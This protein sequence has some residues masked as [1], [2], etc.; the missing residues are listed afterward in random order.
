MEKIKEKLKTIHY[1]HY[2]GIV[3]T[4][5][6]ILCSIFLFPNAF[7]R[8]VESIK[9]LWNSICYYFKEMFDLDINAIPT[10]NESSSVG[11]TPFF[12]LPATWE[13]FQIKWGEFWQLFINGDNIQE[14]LSHLTTLL[15]NFSKIFL[16]I[17][18]PMFIILYFLFQRYLSSE[19][20]DYNKDSK[21]LTFFKWLATKTYIPAK[22]W[23]KQFLSFIGD[24]KYKKIWFWIWAFN[25][26]FITII[27]E[28][29]AFYLYFCV[30]FEFTSIYKQVYK[31]VRDLSV[32]IAFIPPV[33]WLVLAYLFL[34]YIRKKIGST[35]GDNKYIINELGVGYRIGED[36]QE[37]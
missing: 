3:I 26:N 8:I 35:P 9:D 12:N 24:N 14:Y 29:L 22:Q 4:I 31:L 28:F 15:Y 13:E 11:F 34:C 18:A 17:V 30:A 16:L 32:M 23:C 36:A 7:I 33:V 20:T 1:M 2:I 6:F 10:V 19:N 5:A 37:P 27:I 21:T 25:F